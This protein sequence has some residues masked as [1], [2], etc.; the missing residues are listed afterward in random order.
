MH[1]GP[2]KSYD[3]VKIFTVILEYRSGAHEAPAE[4]RANRRRDERA[5]EST[6]FSSFKAASVSPVAR[7]RLRSIK[8]ELTSEL[9]SSPK[10]PKRRA[11][12]SSVPVSKPDSLPG[13]PV[14]GHSPSHAKRVG[15][16]A[17][18]SVSLILKSIA[19]IV[20]DSDRGFKR[21]FVQH[22]KMR[23]ARFKAICFL[24]EVLRKKVLNIKFHA[25][26][27]VVLHSKGQVELLG[28]PPATSVTVFPVNNSIHESRLPYIIRDVEKPSLSLYAGL[29][30]T[31]GVILCVQRIQK[32]Q[33]FAALRLINSL[34]L[35]NK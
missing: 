5:N 26:T 13:S 27:A 2:I 11:L 10:V 32:E 21:D 29:G 22:L 23:R 20:E 15:M 4:D 12:T 28:L 8:A 17:G 3:A 7:A 25:M 30:R 31:F 16:Y 24:D 19:R 6:G 9:R 34:S 14:S 35:R 33:A 1:E 18:F